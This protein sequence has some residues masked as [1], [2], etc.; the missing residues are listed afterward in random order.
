MPHH[1]SESPTVIRSENTNKLQMPQPFNILY[2]ERSRLSICI[3]ST[4]E[5]WKLAYLF[6][7]VSPEY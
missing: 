6:W 7:D 3:T 1:Y 5:C 4:L 2:D